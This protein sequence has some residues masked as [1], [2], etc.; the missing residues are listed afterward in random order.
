[1]YCSGSREIFCTCKWLHQMT[2]KDYCIEGKS[3]RP[4]EI[5]QEISM[6][7]FKVCALGHSAAST[8]SATHTHDHYSPLGPTY[9]YSIVLKFLNSGSSQLSTLSHADHWSVNQF[10]AKNTDPRRKKMFIHFCI[11]TEAAWG[12]PRHDQRRVA[13]GLRHHDIASRNIE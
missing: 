1:M 7:I 12:A 5:R 2:H 11:R 6:L 3:I 9:R 8:Q 10:R 13:W 4:Q